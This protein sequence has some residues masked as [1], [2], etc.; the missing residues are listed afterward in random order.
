MKTNVKVIISL[1]LVGFVGFAMKEAILGVGIDPKDINTKYRAQDD[2][3]SYVN[4][5]WIGRNPIPGSE[6]S[7]AIS[8]NCR[9]NHKKHFKRY[10]LICRQKK[11][12]L[13]APMSN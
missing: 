9:I 2:F 4:S 5:I 1:A 3:Y 11:V 7:W 12:L 8:T 6:N 13:S 10:A